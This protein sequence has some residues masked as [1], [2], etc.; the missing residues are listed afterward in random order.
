M[1][2]GIKTGSVEEYAFETNLCLIHSKLYALSDKYDMAGL[3]ALCS[4][5]FKKASFG[6][7]ALLKALDHIYGSTSTTHNDLRAQ[8]AELVQRNYRDI[9]QN[10]KQ[11][12][13]I[14]V[15]FLK[16][17]QLGL[18]F[19][20]HLF[21]RRDLWCKNC[22]EFVGTFKLECRDRFEDERCLCGLTRLCGSKQLLLERDAKG[23]GLWP[24]RFEHPGKR[25]KVGVNKNRPKRELE[26]F[27]LD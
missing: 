18:D 1:V 22:D 7:D 16:H 24:M 13:L 15:A 21:K 11:M 14:S 17:G 4:S 6:M 23:M 8:A 5:K 26:V 27:L 12:E 19:F 25:A 20:S 9:V 3:R 2:G 10:S